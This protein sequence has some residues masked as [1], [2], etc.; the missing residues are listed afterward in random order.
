MRC[1]QILYIFVLRAEKVTIF[2]AILAQKSGADPDRG[3]RGLSHG[4]IFSALKYSGLTFFMI[5]FKLNILP[6]IHYAYLGQRFHIINRAQCFIFYFV[7]FFSRVNLD[8]DFVSK[9]KKLPT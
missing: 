9:T 1:L 4:Q 2:A 6:Y 7:N 5:L 8:F 3:E